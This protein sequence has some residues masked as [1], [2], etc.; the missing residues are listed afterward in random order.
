MS[1]EVNSFLPAGCIWRTVKSIQA[2]QTFQIE[3]PCL[4]AMHIFFFKWGRG[5]V[6]GC[7][8]KHGGMEESSP[9][10]NNTFASP[11]NWRQSGSESGNQ[12]PFLSRR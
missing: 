4:V 9:T 7:A 12:T 2:G 1:S 10:G 8:C 3:T 5:R 6:C 11:L